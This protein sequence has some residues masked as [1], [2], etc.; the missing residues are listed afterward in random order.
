MLVKYLNFDFFYIRVKRFKHSVCIFEMCTGYVNVQKSS[1]FRGGSVL[2]CGNTVLKKLL[3]GAR[4]VG[5][6]R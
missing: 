6:D 2:S 4:S 5:G 3:I 1:M